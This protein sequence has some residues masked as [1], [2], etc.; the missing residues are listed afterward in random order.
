MKLATTAV[1]LGMLSI[2]SGTEAKAVTF[3]DSLT[4]NS[5]DSNLYFDVTSGFGASLTPNGAVLTHDAGTNIGHAEIVGN[6]TFSGNFTLSVFDVNPATL[7][8]N[9]EAGLSVG[10]GITFSDIFHYADSNDVHSNP[11]IVGVSMTYTSGISGGTFTISG[12]SNDPLTLAL[13]LLEEYDGTV[14]NTITFRD[15]S[16]TADTVSS[17]FVTSGVPESS[18]WA[19][20]LLGFAGLGFIGYRRRKS[21]M[22]ETSIAMLRKFVVRL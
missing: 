13:F 22:R 16:L 6:F 15:L 7:S 8:P 3:F 5:L 9:G 4:G 1:L 21:A 20:M 11:N 18:T 17:N 2:V 10:N 19:M 14:T 12:N